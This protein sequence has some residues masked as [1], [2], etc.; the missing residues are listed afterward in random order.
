MGYLR[1]L[2]DNSL[3]WREFSLTRGNPAE[4]GRIPE[5]DDKS[6]VVWGP[7]L[8]QKKDHGFWKCNIIQFLCVDTNISLIRL[9][10]GSQE[11]ALKLETNQG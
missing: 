6:L 5:K 7:S 10:Q 8:F 3:N 9:V 2:R 1:K 4:G 11:H